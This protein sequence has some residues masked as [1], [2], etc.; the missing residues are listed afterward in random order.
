MEKFEKF[1]KAEK[2]TLYR[3]IL[4]VP[5]EFVKDSFYCSVADVEVKRIALHING[6]YAGKD[7]VFVKEKERNEL[8]VG[9]A[10]PYYRFAKNEEVLNALEGGKLSGMVLQKESIAD[11]SVKYDV[12]EEPNCVLIIRNSYIPGRSL[13]IMLYYNTGTAFIPVIKLKRVHTELL[14]R[15]KIDLTEKLKEFR[16]IVPVVKSLDELPVVDAP[17]EFL[18]MVE[19]ITKVS[20]RIIGGERVK[21]EKRFGEE[22]MRSAIE[23]EWSTLKLIS[24]VLN[25]GFRE[26]VTVKR[27][28]ESVI[29]EGIQYLASL[30]A[31]TT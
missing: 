12:D 28:T 26:G 17:E 13:S 29:Y 24:E 22:I 10:S 20:Y 9:Y 4:N 11:V 15:N 23:N 31:S 18:E 8:A 7:I 14:L 5:E 16:K 3:E 2:E 6:V 21:I 1:G 27:K 30:S 25:R 19:G